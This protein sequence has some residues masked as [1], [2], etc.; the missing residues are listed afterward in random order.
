MPDSA[1]RLTRKPGEKMTN[2]N[3][4]DYLH[5]AENLQY[6]RW[7]KSFAWCPVTTINKER[8]WMRTIYKRV[9]TI[10]TSIPPFPDSKFRKTE[11]ATLQDVWQIQ[12][13]D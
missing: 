11:Y 7:Y 4:V 13:K 5:S 9:R 8:V 12:L 2:H 6:T 3:A 10:R 1:L